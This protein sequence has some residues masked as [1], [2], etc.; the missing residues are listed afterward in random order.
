MNI[1]KYEQFIYENTIFSEVTTNDLVFK[2]STFDMN[3]RKWIFKPLKL[4]GH[5]SVFINNI[6][7]GSFNIKAVG[8]VYDVALHGN[9]EYPEYIKNWKKIDVDNILK[10]KEQFKNSIYLEG[11]FNVEKEYRNKGIGKLIIKKLFE[12]YPQ[13][14]SIFLY[15]MMAK[16]KSFW[17]N[18]LKGEPILC[19]SGVD[20]SPFDND[21]VYLIK[22]DRNKIL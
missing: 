22:L 21:L 5:I 3:T 9:T 17:I 4:N 2:S 18:Q 14:K 20:S 19:P 15:A 11:G 1:L 7:V 13:Y 6:K 16:S 8:D 10:N 12:N